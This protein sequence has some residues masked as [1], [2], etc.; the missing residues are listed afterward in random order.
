MIQQALAHSEAFS[1]Q[2][3]QPSPANATN[4]H[5]S[6]P[7]GRTPEVPRT[8][9]EPPE[10]REHATG[11]PP[12]ASNLR[13]HSSC[14]QLPPFASSTEHR[15]PET[16]SPNSVSNRGALI[17]D[18]HIHVSNVGNVLGT[19]YNYTEVEDHSTHKRSRGELYDYLTGYVRDRI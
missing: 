3:T 6:P 16:A 5:P 9:S 2:T 8:Y 7:A 15:S 12:S 14:P 17:G 18:I 10:S 4:E 1:H 13:R 19:K 11:A